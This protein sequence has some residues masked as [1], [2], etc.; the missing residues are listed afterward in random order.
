MNWL[1]GVEFEGWKVE[2]V[3]GVLVIFF[4]DL[5]VHALSLDLW[6]Q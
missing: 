2:E 1:I 6:T 3:D 4:V 5:S